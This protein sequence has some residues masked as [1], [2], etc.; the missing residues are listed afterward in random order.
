MSSVAGPVLAAVLVAAAGGGWMEYLEEVPLP[1][2]PADA[3]TTA[4]AAGLFDRMVTAMEA[5][6]HLALNDLIYS[7]RPHPPL[8]A[9]P[10]VAPDII[11]QLKACRVVRPLYF[12]PDE[13]I[14]Y[15]LFCEA[16][17]ERLE[18]FFIVKRD[19]DR[20]WRIKQ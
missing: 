20:K 9:V 2:L 7:G 12:F 1:E 13:R 19:Y 5:R 8:T 17:G 11:R 14:V 4:E 18:T 16:A 6:D 10:P 3:P 15:F